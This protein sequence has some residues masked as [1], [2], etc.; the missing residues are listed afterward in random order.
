LTAA[1]V[2]ASD[3]GGGNGSEK[4]DSQQNKISNQ[5]KPSLY[6]TRGGPLLDTGAASFMSL[7]R[8]LP[9]QPIPVVLTRHLS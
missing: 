9:C 1:A 5:G 3:T 2:R 7:Q 4:R 8:A 6:K